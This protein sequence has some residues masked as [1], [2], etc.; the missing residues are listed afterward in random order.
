MD[1]GHRKPADD[2]SSCFINRGPEEHTWILRRY[3]ES[4]RLPDP[5][6]GRRWSAE[7]G[8]ALEAAS[9]SLLLR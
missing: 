8:L 5:P 9:A 7:L 1:S 4:S 6:L 3:R 2:Q